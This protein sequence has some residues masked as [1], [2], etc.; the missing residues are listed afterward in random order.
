MNNYKIVYKLFM[1]NQN[2]YVNE[3]NKENVNFNYEI[4]EV[5]VYAL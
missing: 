1:Q 5:D 4:I 3:L 2:I